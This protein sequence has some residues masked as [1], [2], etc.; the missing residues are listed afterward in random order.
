M[1]SPS[2]QALIEYVRFASLLVSGI[3]S[4]H[5]IFKWQWLRGSRKFSRGGGGGGAP[6]YQG[7]SNKF[8][9]CKKTCLENR[10]GGVAEP[11]D[12]PM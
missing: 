5:L 12:R 11:L 8:Y 6:S 10:G 4:C 9:H 1:V 2:V 3:L 7:R